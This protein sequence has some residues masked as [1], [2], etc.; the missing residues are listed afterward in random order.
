MSDFESQFEA[1][2][3]LQPRVDHEQAT[4]HLAL[5]AFHAR[6]DRKRVIVS[7]MA[8]FLGAAA[9]IAIAGIFFFH[10]EPEVHRTVD[11]GDLSR[12][13]MLQAY[14]ELRDTF[15]EGLAALAWVDGQMQ[16]YPGLVD[17]HSVQ[18]AY[19]EM[20]IGTTPIKVV[21]AEGAVLPVEVDGATILIELLPD[22]DGMLT[23]SGEN[24]YWSASDRYMPAN[25]RVLIAERAEE[26][27][28]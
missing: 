12:E 17:G 3:T 27:I 18:S 22:A 2:P 11:S 20:L 1:G 10:A 23:V 6:R 15:P 5:Q 4:V 24:F 26:V 21:A 28:L 25:R 8:S 7:F 16:I 9:A 13:T 19:L 14:T